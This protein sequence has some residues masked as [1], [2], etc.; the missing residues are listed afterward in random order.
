MQPL[1]DIR[2]SMKYPG[3]YTLVPPLWGGAV[4]TVVLLLFP[5]YPLNF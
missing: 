4:K 5:I 3:N 2:K 1:N